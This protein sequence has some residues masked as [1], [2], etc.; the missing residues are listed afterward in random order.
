MLCISAQVCPIMP[1]SYHG[2]QSPI[3]HHH[4][5]LAQMTPFLL[6]A[7]LSHS[8]HNVCLVANSVVNIST[9]VNEQWVINNNN[10]NIT[11]QHINPML[12]CIGDIDLM[13]YTSDELVVPQEHHVTDYVR[14]AY[15]CVMVM[16]NTNRRLHEIT[17]NK[18]TSKPPR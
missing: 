11:S 5:R 16:F 2:K 10:N 17:N 1:L 13:C 3:R 18:T 6:M 8:A 4:I 7:S 12:P 9:R 15:Q 14:L